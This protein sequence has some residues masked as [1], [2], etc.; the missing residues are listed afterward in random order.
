LRKKD[1]LLNLK[2][3]HYAVLSSQIHHTCPEFTSGGLTW[4][5]VATGNYLKPLTF[6]AAPTY[7]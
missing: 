6:S 2:L 5:Q 1:F 4:R 3:R 7:I